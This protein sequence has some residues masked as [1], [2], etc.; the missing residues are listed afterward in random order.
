MPQTIR[1]LGRLRF[2]GFRVPL[3]LRAR[4]NGYA[5]QSIDRHSRQVLADPDN[6]PPTLLSKLYARHDQKKDTSEETMDFRELIVEARANIVAGTDTTAS[7]LTYMF[8]EL[9]RHPEVQTRLSAELNA[10]PAD[11]T[12]G[13]LREAP[14]LSHVIDETLR[15][16][17]PVPALLPRTVPEG[18]LY[19]CGH[20][21][22]PGCSV[23]TQA[24]TM[25][26]DSA[27]FPAP[28]EFQPDRWVRPTQAMKDAFRPFGGGSR[29]CI[30]KHLAVMELRL[31]TAL[32]YRRH[33]QGLAVAYGAT[34]PDED[35]EA[36]RG[37]TDDDMK[38]NMAFLMGPKGL[39]C[40]LRPR[41]A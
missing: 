13:T 5:E 30:G 28:E 34:L 25:H 8:W 26:R 12:A 10:L 2:P 4:L 27:V 21:I 17:S 23:G 31:V 32:L 22:P 3:D 1:V 41:A 11:F 29:I 20:F 18:G 37:F 35:S 7:G 14:L 36:H 40:L 24:F 15:L 6:V 33:P 16:H 39:R 19:T 9:A 38:M